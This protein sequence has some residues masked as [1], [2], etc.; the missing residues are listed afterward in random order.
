[1]RKN[2]QVSK[3]RIERIRQIMSKAHSPYSGLTKQGA[4][5]EI[6]KTREKLW[7]EKFAAHS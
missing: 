6:R 5:N 7:E 3:K 4:I 1:M 2:I